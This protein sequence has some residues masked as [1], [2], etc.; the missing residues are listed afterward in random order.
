M[1]PSR[2]TRIPRTPSRTH[3]GGRPILA[4][5]HPGPSRPEAKSRSEVSP[6][7]AGRRRIQSHGE[8]ILT[9]SDLRQENGRALLGLPSGAQGV[10]PSQSLERAIELGIVDAGDYRIPKSSIQPASID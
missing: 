9:E 6:M 4:G 1:R 2:H 8:A 5:P 7:M 3:G 10:L